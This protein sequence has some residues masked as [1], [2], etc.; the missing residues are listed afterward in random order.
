MCF[1]IGL[2]FILLAFTQFYWGCYTNFFAL[3]SSQF[4][5]ATMSRAL[6]GLIFGGFCWLVAG[7]FFWLGESFG[8]GGWSS[9]SKYVE[10]KHYDKDGRFTGS[11][12]TERPNRS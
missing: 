4:S 9:N 1:L 8:G 7:F 5:D 11:T 10:H 12:V 6:L 3:K 2:F